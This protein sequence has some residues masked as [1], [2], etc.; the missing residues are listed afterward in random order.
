MYLRLANT[1]L[2][3]LLLW[4]VPQSGSALQVGPP[5]PATEVRVSDTQINRAM[6]ERILDDPEML[7]GHPRLL[8]AL[9]F[10]ERDAVETIEELEDRLVFTV[11]RDD[12]ELRLVVFIEQG[13]AACCDRV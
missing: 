8:A 4:K 3:C 11:W 10:A 12:R 13:A 7:L 9:G 6:A 5:A 1:A 2:L